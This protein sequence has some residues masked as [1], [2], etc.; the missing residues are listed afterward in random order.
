MSS[1]NK[2]KK[3]HIF[4]AKNNCVCTVQMGEKKKPKTKKKKK[5]K[6]NK[7]MKRKGEWFSSSQFSSHFGEKTF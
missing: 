4:L 6:N 3:Q 7:K 1:L 5:K 2:T